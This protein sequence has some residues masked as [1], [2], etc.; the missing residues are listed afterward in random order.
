MLQK[1]WIAN[2][3]NADVKLSCALDCIVK[4]ALMLWVASRILFHHSS[5]GSS[6]V[7]SVFQPA[8]YSDAIVVGLLIVSLISRKV[9]FNLASVLLILCLM[10]SSVV[11]FLAQHDVYPFVL[12]LFLFA[13]RNNDFMSLA[14]CHFI[15][16]LCGLCLAIALDCAMHLKHGS[17]D[18]QSFVMLRY[19]FREQCDLGFSL[20]A[21][22]G[23]ASMVIS[24]RKM[25]RAWMIACVLCTLMS[26]FLL[27]SKKAGVFTLCLA[28]CM[29]ICNSRGEEVSQLLS[30]RQARVFFCAVPVTLFCVSGDLAHFY[31]L[32]SPKCAYICAAQTLGFVFSACLM[33]LSAGVFLQPKESQ[34]CSSALVLLILYL[35]FSLFEGK[36]MFLEFNVTLLLLSGAVS[37][38]VDSWAVE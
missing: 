11:A 25:R 22:L 30:R 24:S 23:S 14:K 38:L 10:L 17:F 12:A 15:A 29:G 31:Q 33:A 28:L 9:R 27:Q 18:V 35:L 16:I 13:S 34:P 8:Q 32:G 1:R 37:F 2:N 19:G 36:P 3:K 26:F 7:V 5:V 21:L 20:F 6:Y 4:V